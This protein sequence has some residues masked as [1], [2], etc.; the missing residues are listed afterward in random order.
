M[1]VYGMAIMTAMMKFD[2][3]VANMITSHW[4]P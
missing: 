1:F 3:F 2:M 4:R